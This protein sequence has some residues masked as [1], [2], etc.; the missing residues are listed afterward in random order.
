MTTTYPAHSIKPGD[1]ISGRTVA[2]MIRPALRG[3]FYIPFEDGSRLEVR[4]L[5][6][7][8]TVD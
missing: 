6:T 5:E 7:L 4:T 1:Q 2:D 8:V 3:G